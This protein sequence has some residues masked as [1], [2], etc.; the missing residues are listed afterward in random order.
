MANAWINVHGIISATSEIQSGMTSYDTNGS[1]N[2]SS[3]VANNIFTIPTG[4]THQEMYNING[5]KISGFVKSN[6]S[7]VGVKIELNGKT[8]ENS[9]SGGSGVYQNTCS[10]GIMWNESNYGKI[11]IFIPVYYVGSAG[12]LGLGYYPN[13]MKTDLYN[14]IVNNPYIPPKK[15]GGSGSG[16]IGNSLVSNK[17]MVGYDVPTSDAESTKTESV[18]VY[19]PAPLANMPKMG[20]GFARIKFLREYDPVPSE[21]KDYIDIINGKEF[22][23]NYYLSDN[24]ICNCNASNASDGN[25]ILT[26]S[27]DYSYVAKTRRELSEWNNENKTYAA[28]YD[29]SDKITLAYSLNP[30]NIYITSSGNDY[31]I[32]T[33]VLTNVSVYKY[34][35]TSYYDI[36]IR[37]ANNKWRHWSVSYT[38]AQ[39]I[40]AFT[41]IGTLENCFKMIAMNFRNVDIYVDGVCWSKV[42]P[43]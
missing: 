7:K 42:S 12:W 15:S 43:D 2:V 9:I 31:Q 6:G 35:N 33:S 41:Y 10:I 37:Y 40:E 34:Y 27:K 4:D 18:Q 11:I 25:A 14:W 26:N 28:Y 24:W 32:T 5:L 8:S 20:D 36:G 38:S 13:R 39:T 29:S 30:V 23:T 19:S 22:A 1:N 17:K 21:Y 3:Y 16:Y